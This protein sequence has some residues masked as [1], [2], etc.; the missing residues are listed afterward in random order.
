MINMA[1]AE[2]VLISS[3]TFIPLRIPYV[4]CELPHV[5]V[6]EGVKKDNILHLVQNVVLFPYA[7]FCAISYGRAIFKVYSHRI[8]EKALF[9]RL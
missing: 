8:P 5:D 9:K 6:S 7:D 3:S 1:K 4:N 2:K